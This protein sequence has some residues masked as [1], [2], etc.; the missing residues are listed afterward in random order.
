MTTLTVTAEREKGVRPLLGAAI[1]NEIRLLM[2]GIRKTERRLQ[3]FER[4]HGLTTDIFIQK[5]ETGE[6]N[7]NLVWDEWIGESRTLARLHDNLEALQGVRIE[8]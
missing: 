1:G 3:E 7:E 2:A 6:M 5:Y 8:D 4:A